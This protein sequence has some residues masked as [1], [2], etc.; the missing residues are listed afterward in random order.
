MRYVF[1]LSM[2]VAVLGAV[3][4]LIEVISDGTVVWLQTGTIVITFGG[5]GLIVILIVSLC[6]FAARYRKGKPVPSL[7]VSLISKDF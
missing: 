7:T 1:A 3:L 4:K 2:L 5:L 6:V